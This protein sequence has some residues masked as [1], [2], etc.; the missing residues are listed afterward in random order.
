MTLNVFINTY[1][2]FINDSLA[3]LGEETRDVEV[4]TSPRRPNLTPTSPDSKP[5]CASPPKIEFE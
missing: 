2:P 1:A 3:G 4:S 5:K